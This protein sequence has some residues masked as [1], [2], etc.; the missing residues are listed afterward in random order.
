MMVFIIAVHI[1]VCLGLILVILVQ[2][3]RGGGLVESFSNVESMF[4]PKTNVFM[5][6]LT[7]IFASLFLLTCVSLA[8]LA[9]RQSRSLVEGAR[10]NKIQNQTGQVATS[11]DNATQPVSETTQ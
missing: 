5:T 6:R 4:G 1:L 3:G 9:S 7:T 8:F 2:S 11:T 10:L